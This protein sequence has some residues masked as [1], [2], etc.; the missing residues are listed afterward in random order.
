MIAPLFIYMDRPDKS[1]KVEVIARYL[2]EQG[3]K[4]KVMGDFFE[5][6]GKLSK[7][8]ANG[9]AR[10]RVLDPGKENSL[11]QYPTDNEIESETQIL[12][13]QEPM[14]LRR[15]LSNVYDAFALAGF[16]KSLVAM[17]GFHIIFT[18]RMIASFEG[19]RYHGR[20]IVMDYPMAIISTT[21]IV[22]APA[23]PKEF[24]IKQAA[25]YKAK[26]A[27]FVTQ[28]EE[29]YLDELKKEFQGRFIEYGDARLTE[30]VKG[31][32]LQAL[33]YLFWGEKFCNN[34]DCRLY[35]AHT[36][37][38]MIHAQIESGRLCMKHKKLIR[39]GHRMV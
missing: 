6:Q 18:S 2:R 17:K 36:Q 20:T 32:S 1:L 33:Y 9:L 35:N 29:A 7:T 31:Y 5:R 23:K 27:G 8:I 14:R 28:D 13:S 16:L 15:D 12:K 11:N 38:S 3:F 39:K 21:G 24:Y 4:P 22:E 34:P 25:Y 37:D 10:C 19:T 26:Q 30:V